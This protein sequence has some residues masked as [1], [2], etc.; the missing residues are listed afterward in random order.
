VEPQ[1]I[2]RSGIEDSSDDLDLVDRIF[3]LGRAPLRA[4]QLNALA[5]WP[6]PFR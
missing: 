3:I 1:N 6:A 2:P 5:G 4:R